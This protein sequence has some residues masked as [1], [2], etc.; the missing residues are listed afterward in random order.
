MSAPSP[1]IASPSSALTTRRGWAEHC[2][3]HLELGRVSNLPTVWSNVFMALILASSAGFSPTTH[4]WPTLMIGIV[5]M[6]AFYIAGMY[7]NDAFDAAIDAEERPSRPIPS[8]RVTQRQ[9]FIFSA[10]W[11]FLG[12][13]LLIAFMAFNNVE[14]H[15]TWPVIL[16]TTLLTAAIIGYDAYHKNNPLSPLIMACCRVLVVVTLYTVAIALVELP[17]PA[18]GWATHSMLLAVCGLVLLYLTGLTFIAKFEGSSSMRH[19]WPIIILLT[20]VTYGLVSMFTDPL[21]L[22]P[23]A[24][25]ALTIAYAVWRVR[26]NTSGHIPKAIGAL[27]AGISLIDALV[28]AALGS[29]VGMCF[30]ITAFG[31]TLGLQRKIAGT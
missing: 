18:H 4:L 20:P 29:L 1:S 2:R 21:A 23:S 24:L 19:A 7:L 15:A 13:G 26:S 16:S 14:V 10:L 3:T 25:L 11:F 5:S 31:L 12:W 17:G 6:S 8:G 30:G 9:V 27:I 28:M 22:L